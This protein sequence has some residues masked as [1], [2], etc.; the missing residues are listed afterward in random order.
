[1][2]QTLESIAFLVR[3]LKPEDFRSA[4]KCILIQLYVPTD[5]IGYRCLVI[6]IPMYHDDPEQSLTK[7]IY[8]AVAKCLNCFS[9]KKV[10]KNIRDAISVAWHDR[11]IAVWQRFFPKERRPSNGEFISRI[12][13]ILGVWEA[14]MRA[15]KN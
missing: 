15:N 8:P 1:M 10:E 12:S 6:T 3:H 4:V 2:D 7:E 14:C 11:D 5:S 9:W 13:E